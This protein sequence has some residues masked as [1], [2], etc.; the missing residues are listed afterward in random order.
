MSSIRRLAVAAVT[1]S[2][3]ALGGLVAATPASAATSDCPAA[4]SCGWRDYNYV[5]GSSGARNIRFEYSIDWLGNYA[6]SDTGAT[7]N[8]SVSSLYNN[9]NISTAVWYQDIR[10][11]GNSVT[12]P[13]QYGNPDLRVNGFNDKASSGTFI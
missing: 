1:V 3:V 11:S 6:W 8:D 7:V 10:F 4:Y 5:S 13:R 9:G 2:L 12:L